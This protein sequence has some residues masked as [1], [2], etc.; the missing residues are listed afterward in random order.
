MYFDESGVACKSETLLNGIK[1]F[2]DNNGVLI[3]KTE[4]N[5]LVVKWIKNAT[6]YWYQK[7]DLTWPK[8]QFEK[9]G[10]KWYYFDNSGYVIS[11]WKQLGVNRYY[12]GD[13]MDG[14]MKTGWQL[15]K[16]K[17][18]YFGGTDDGHMFTG[19]LP[20]EGKYYYLNE[21]GIMQIGGLFWNNNWYYLNNDGSMVIGWKR[22][23][24]GKWYYMNS[25]GAMMRNTII[26]GFKIG[27]DGVYIN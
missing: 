21:D 23:I 15:I 19:L 17:Y 5:N 18:Y 9:I 12:F 24:D 11:G 1:Y 22:N 7:A 27:P 20:Y 3:N 8:N 26:E 2:F 25:S 4:D 10:N 16:N 6:R 14:A 13:I